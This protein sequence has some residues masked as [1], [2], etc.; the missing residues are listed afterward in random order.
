MA[1]PFR[2]RVL[3]EL[4][5]LIESI[6]KND[7]YNYT[8]AGKVVRGRLMFSAETDPLPLVAINEAPL[9]DESQAVPPAS[10]TWTGPWV[11]YIQG[12]VDDDKQNPTDPAHYLLADVRKVLAQE[13]TRAYRANNI[14][15]MG[16]RVLDIRF[17]G[18]V[19]RPAEE[20]VSAYAN[21]L[22]SVTLEIAENLN[23]PYH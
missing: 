8:L 23:D 22:M 3:K 21:F 1:D 11:I 13:R 19:V 6:S 4:T 20:F 12:W 2:L 16:G 17:G 9:P 15:G 7:G 5:T 14:L 18:C 10:P